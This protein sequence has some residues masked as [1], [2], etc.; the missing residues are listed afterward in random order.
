MP[1]LFFIMTIKGLY[2]KVETLQAN[3][4]KL[5]GESVEENTTYL[6]M[7]NKQQLLAG[8]RSDGKD[9]FPTYQE[10]PYFETLAQAQAYSD[11]KDRITPNPK[12]K[13]GVPNL[14]INGY[15]YDSRVIKV[16]GDRIIYDGNTFG[17][18]EKYGKE[19]N[20]LGGEYKEAFLDLHLRPTI[21]NKITS[22]IGLK[23]K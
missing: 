9:L 1:S 3:Q 23:F 8:K 6:G 16:S 7:L 10:D 19:I 15:Y 21:Q 13:P 17:L 22:I 18:E 4:E 2:K 5:A 11:W 12:R 14:Y 20:G